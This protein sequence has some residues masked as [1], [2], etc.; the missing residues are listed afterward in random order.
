[1]DGGRLHLEAVL[2]D[3]SGGE[4]KMAALSGAREEAEE[5]GIAVAAMLLL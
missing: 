1:M 5:L 4:P 3:H 2:F